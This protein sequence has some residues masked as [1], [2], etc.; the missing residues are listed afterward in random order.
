[1]ERFRTLQQLEKYLD[2]ATARIL[3]YHMFFQPLNYKRTS[4]KILTAIREGNGIEILKTVKPEE[5]LSMPHHKMFDLCNMRSKVEISDTRQRARMI[6]LQELKKTNLTTSKDSGIKC[7]RCKS[8]DIIFSFLQTRSAD[9]GTTT[10][11]ECLQC[12]SR[13]KM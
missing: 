3:E 10:F 12:G 1:M 4:V 6:R 5:F 11:C 13:W 2:E 7:S 9:E 8:T